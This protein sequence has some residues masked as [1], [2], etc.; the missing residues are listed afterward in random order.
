MTS[1]AIG[2][3][4]E[5]QP[6]KRQGEKDYILELYGKKKEHNKFDFQSLLDREMEKLNE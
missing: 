3:V 5:R 2:E 1:I 6:M 4:V